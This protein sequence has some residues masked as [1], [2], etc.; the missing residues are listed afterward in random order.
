MITL[1]TGGP[2]TGKTAWLLN[3]LIEL[4]KVEPDRLLFVHGVRN[5]RG[6]RHETIYCRSQLCDICRAQDSAIK[7]LADTDRPPKFVENWTAWKEPNSLIVVD[8][9]QRIWRPTNGASSLHESISALETHRHY[10][11]DFL[12][13]SQGP[14]LFHNFIRLLVGRHVH[15][16]A[17]WHGRK[18]YE[19][20]ECRQDVQSRSDAVER[21]YTLPK[22]VYGMYDSAEVHT[23]QEHRKP[24]AFYFV[25]IFML[26]A[27]ALVGYAG[28]N[29]YQRTQPKSEAASPNEAQAASPNEVQAV[30]PNE[31]QA[32]SPNEAQTKED[33][34]RQYTPMVVGVPWSAPIYRELAK[35]VSMPRI[36]GC[37][38]TS[39]IAS[40]RCACY[41]QQATIVEVSQE[42]C[43]RL[44]QR[45]AFDPFLRDEQNSQTAS[46]N[47][48]L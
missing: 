23:I 17:K 40:Y 24:M 19:W 25:A 9:V 30:L 22:H 4:I 2:G 1:I 28:H 26:M 43:T 10:G 3:N 32:A 12:L 16:V 18:Q 11:V 20:P 42:V 36:V 21:T 15:L 34:I 44:V 48:P 7:L 31:A 29:I 13:I 45:R 5:L 41:T 38:N 35:P 8:E 14:H 39:D 27:V 6:I 33:I 47:L 37:I 46:T